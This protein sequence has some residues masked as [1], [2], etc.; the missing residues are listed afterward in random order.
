MTKYNSTILIIVI[1]DA[2]TG[3]DALELCVKDKRRAWKVQKAKIERQV[4]ALEEQTRRLG[5][6]RRQYSWQQAEGIINEEELRT[7]FKQ[8]KSEESIIGEQMSRLEQFRHE[9]APLDIAIFKKLAEFWPIEII[10]NL[11]NAPD[12]VMDRFAEMFDLHVAI[13]LDGSRN[14][15]HVDLTANIPLEME[16]DKPSAYDMVFGS[17]GRGAGGW[18]SLKLL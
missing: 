12:D 2:M 13:R 9:P 6:K 8:I 1:I 18:I 17:S 16:G 14:G 10:S 5:Q 4:K 15:Y 7:A 11:S 3:L